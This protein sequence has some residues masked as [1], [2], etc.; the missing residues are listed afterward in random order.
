VV[1]PEDY[2]VLERLY[3]A[4]V[5]VRA[6]AAISVVAPATAMLPRVAVVVLH[7]PAQP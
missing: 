1:S 5:L 6:V 3:L 2:L 4:K 7:S